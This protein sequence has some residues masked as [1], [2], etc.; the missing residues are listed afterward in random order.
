MKPDK[1]G[2]WEWFEEDGTKRLVEVFDVASE[3]RKAN[4]TEPP[5]FRV[6]WW[7]GY[8][9]VN[10]EVD[11][12]YNC[13]GEVVEKDHIMPSEW[14][15]RWGN[16][17]GDNLSLPEEQLYLG[18]TPEQRTEILKRYEDQSTKH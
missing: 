3:L 17:I 6:Y 12:L 15:D 7:G 5:Y 1:A 13:K 2:I 11:D 16:R 14:P 18:P 4:G 10:E 8:Y 9:N